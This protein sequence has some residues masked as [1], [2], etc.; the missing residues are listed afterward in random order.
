MTNDTPTPRTDRV[1][2]R[3]TEDEVEHPHA[4]AFSELCR[5]LER[6]TIELKAKLEI[7]HKAAN[8]WFK[9]TNYE[10]NKATELE[11]K[12]VEAKEQLEVEQE[13]NPANVCRSCGH[14]GDFWFDRTIIDDGLGYGMHY[15]C[16]KCGKSNDQQECEV[17]KLKAQLTTTRAQLEQARETF[18]WLLGLRGDFPKRPDT[19]GLYWWRREL[20]ERL[21]ITG[22]Q[23]NE[24][25]K[26]AAAQG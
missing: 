6:E 16:E 4:L 2:A 7:E 25:A 26:R 19:G 11:D 18:W 5:E 20:R 23:L 1:A 10:H 9:E 21:G 15:R 13:R 22:N 17:E 12:L 8:H 24:E 14:V 3:F